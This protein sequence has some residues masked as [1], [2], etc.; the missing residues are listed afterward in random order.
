[1]PCKW[2]QR[3]LTRYLQKH[4]KPH[5]ILSLV[6]HFFFYN[7]RQLVLK[8]ILYRDRIYERIKANSTIVTHSS[9]TEEDF[10]IMAYCTYIHT[11]HVRPDTFTDMR[12]TLTHTQRQDINTRH[13]SQ[14]PHRPEYPLSDN[15]D[16]LTTE[17]DKGQ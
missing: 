4:I 1:M 12:H 13:V 11:V 5:L 14:N 16:S 2:I 6:T 10:S 15:A 9:W 3:R 7:Y 17:C 8:E